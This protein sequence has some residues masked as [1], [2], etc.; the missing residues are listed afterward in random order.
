LEQSIKGVLILQ[1]IASALVL[2]CIVVVGF[3]TTESV[4]EQLGAGLVGAAL[5][6][7][8]TLL[9]ARSMRRADRAEKRLGESAKY[10]LAP[11]FSGLLNKLV[12]VGGGLG[13]GLVIGLNPIVL[14]AAYLFVQISASLRLIVSGS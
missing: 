12:I 4:L 2:F 8:S 1:L 7:V 13:F 11:I 14:I 9:S 3:F 10:S 5:A 6:I